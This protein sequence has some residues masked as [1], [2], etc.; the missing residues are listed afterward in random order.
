MGIALRG[1]R[2]RPCRRPRP[3]RPAAR[4]SS[5]PRV[6][7][8]HWLRSAGHSSRPRPPRGS[9]GP[10]TGP[11][12]TRGTRA[13]WSP[14]AR[15]RP[16]EAGQACRD[17]RGDVD[18]RRGARGRAGRGPSCRQP[19]QPGLPGRRAPRGRL[20]APVGCSGPPGGPRAAHPSNPR[21]RPTRPVRRR[22]ATTHPLRSRVAGAGLAHRPRPR[23]GRPRGHADVGYP[24][25]AGPQVARPGRHR[26]VHQPVHGAVRG[27]R[28][29]GEAD[30]GGRERAEPGRVVEPVE[31][32]AGVRVCPAEEREVPQRR[33]GDR[34]RRQVLVRSLPRRRG[35]AA[36]RSRA[37]GAGGRRRPGCTCT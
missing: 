34:G 21:R 23:G 17:R 25:H 28:R 9:P 13:T 2:P 1:V 10:T 26:G 33:S 31:G 35:Q 20:H 18:A 16:R 29:A 11:S 12:A 7:G 22:H 6:R 15:W 27:P 4:R 19:A 32:R 24:R 14:A 3:A 30:A 37:R 8:R 5:L 36:A